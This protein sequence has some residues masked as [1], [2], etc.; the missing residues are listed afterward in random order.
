[1]NLEK[2]SDSKIVGYSKQPDIQREQ[3]GKKYF[4]MRIPEQTKESLKL[5]SGDLVEILFRNQA[6]DTEYFKRDVSATSSSDLKFYV[7]RSVVEEL[8]ID[9]TSLI[10]VFISKD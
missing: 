6:G 4:N 2:F 5:E 9:E 7:P 1:M 3:N 10:D 8:G